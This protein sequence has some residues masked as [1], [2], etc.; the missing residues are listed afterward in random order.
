MN[1]AYID[2]EAKEVKLTHPSEGVIIFAARDDTIRIF[3][4]NEKGEFSPISQDPV[5]NEYEDVF[6]EELPGMPLHQPVEFVI[7][8]E[9]RTKPICKRPYKVGPE[10][11]KGLKKQLDEQERLGLIRPSSSLGVVVFYLSR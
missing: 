3:S 8:L 11:L 5:V 4:L 9:P 1:K 2:C 6:P 10:E 7:K